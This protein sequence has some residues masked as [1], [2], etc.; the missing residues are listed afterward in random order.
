[1]AAAEVRPNQVTFSASVSACEKGDQW[2]R[3]LL[4]LSEMPC[5]GVLPNV[6]SYSAG[7]SA[8]EHCGQWQRALVLLAQKLAARLVPDAHLAERRSLCV[9]VA[10]V[11]ELSSLSLPGLAET[12]DEILVDTLLTAR[13]K[14]SQWQ[15]AFLLLYDS[16]Q[17]PEKICPAAG[18]KLCSIEFC[19]V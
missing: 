15:L 14:R 4:I 16:R 18:P 13:E 1:M 11:S 12:E 6:V 3:A 9:F 7:I 17:T 2:E 19:F 10:G 5:D 8:C